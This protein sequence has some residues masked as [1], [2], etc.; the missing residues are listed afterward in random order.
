[1]KLLYIAS[2]EGEAQLIVA[3]LAAESVEAYA[4]AASPLEVMGV[5]PALGYFGTLQ[6]RI[7]V[8]EEDYEFASLLLQ[9]FLDPESFEEKRPSDWVCQACGAQVEGQFGACWRC[10]ADRVDEA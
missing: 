7:Y 5:N 8:K 9:R 10:G 1:M 3:E 6:S 2:N 4:E